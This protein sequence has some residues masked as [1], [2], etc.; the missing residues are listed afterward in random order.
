MMKT[1]GFQ[2]GPSGR[3]KN[4]LSSHVRYSFTDITIWYTQK[5][6]WYYIMLPRYVIPHYPN[7]SVSQLCWNAGWCMLV[8]FFSFFFW[9]ELSTHIMLL[10]DIFLTFCVP[11]EMLTCAFFR[12]CDLR[13]D[14]RC[15]TP[16]WCLIGAKLASHW[17]G[18][19]RSCALCTLASSVA[20]TC[21]VTCEKNVT[22]FFLSWVSP[23]S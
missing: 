2:W 22:R 18:F 14:S 19:T 23:S 4:L 6:V 13:Y 7:T 20:G 12:W 1:D 5:C 10:Y 17:G 21:F 8:C 11:A 16:V 3:R 9:R 15:D